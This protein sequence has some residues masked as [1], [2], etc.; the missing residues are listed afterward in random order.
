M[1]SVDLVAMLG[2]WRGVLTRLGAFS[3]LILAGER[4]LHQVLPLLKR[5]DV[6]P[7]YILA[8]EGGGR[9]ACGL[10]RI[11]AHALQTMPPTTGICVCDLGGVELAHELK[12]VADFPVLDGFLPLC[13]DMFAPH[14]DPRRIAD[15]LDRIHAARR[16]FTDEPSL[17]LFDAILAFRLSR[18]L[19]LL[20][21]PAIPLYFHP[22]TA[23]RAGDVIIDAGAF[24]GDTA[25]SFA[26][27]ANNRAKI[28]A[29]E[30][31]R[32]NLAALK[33]AVRRAGAERVVEAVPMALSG[34]DGH[35]PFTGAGSSARI[36]GKGE[37]VRSTTLDSFCAARGIRPT[38]IKTDLEGA[39]L[40][41]LRGA[42]E[43][44]RAHRPRLALSVYHR[45]EDLWEI[46]LLAAQLRPGSRLS[47][48]RHQGPESLG[49]IVCY[50]YDTPG[51][52]Q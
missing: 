1:S 26:S 37:R 47:L 39:D 15:N 38:L 17:E 45:P 16:L 14:F 49:E 19:G 23:P 27:A 20:P 3:P 13:H 10:E 21:L 28:F 32:T 44:T 31:D 40:D 52:G 35:V 11:Q 4:L 48:V 2:N 29:F 5:H 43:T 41:A 30:P 9:S 25:L 36:G 42:R 6:H 8:E 51:G 33:G 22:G 7:E 24:D 50:V 46:P 12:S 34:E 18:D